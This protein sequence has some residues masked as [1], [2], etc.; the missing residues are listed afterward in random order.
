MREQ[1]TQEFLF[2]VSLGRAEGAAVASSS[3]GSPD[4]RPDATWNTPFT[5]ST[6]EEAAS[7]WQR[8]RS[9]VAED[10]GE[11]HHLTGA[12]H[13]PAPHLGDT[14]TSGAARAHATHDLATP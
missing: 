7:V 9:L 6:A 11:R 12:N 3:D 14:C 2:Q 13:S 8:E 4:W 10:P 1:K 5:A